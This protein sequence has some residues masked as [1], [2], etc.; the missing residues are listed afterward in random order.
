MD[1]VKK[2]AENAEF[3]RQKRT[4]KEMLKTIEKEI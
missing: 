1:K 2:F 3:Q 4:L